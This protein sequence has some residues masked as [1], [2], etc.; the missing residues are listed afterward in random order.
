MLWMYWQLQVDIIFYF[1]HCLMVRESDLLPEGCRFKSQVRHELSVGGVNNQ[2]SLPPSIPWLRWDPGQPQQYGCPL[3]RVC[4]HGVCVTTVCVHLDGLNTEHTFRVSVTI[5]GHTSLHFTSPIFS[6][7]A[8]RCKCKCS[9]FITYKWEKIFAGFVSFLFQQSFCFFSIY[10]PLQF[11]C[12][13]SLQIM[14]SELIK[15]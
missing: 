15:Q 13:K 12:E 9:C 11:N 7:P 6:L 5:L 1:S 4:V 2:R 3:L 14:L 10:I 8:I